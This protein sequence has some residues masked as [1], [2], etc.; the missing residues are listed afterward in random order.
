MSDVGESDQLVLRYLTL[1]WVVGVLSV[2]LPV[3]LVLGDLTIGS[4]GRLQDSISAYYDTVM[5][6]VFVGVLFA[7]GFFLFAYVGYP[8]EKEGRRWFQQLS[9]DSPWYERLSDNAAGNLAWVFALGVALFPVSG[10][11]LVKTVHFVSATALFLTLSYFSIVLFTKTS[12]TKSPSQ[13]KLARNRIYRWMGG[14]MLSCIGLMLVYNLWL[15]ETVVADWKP[16]LVL[17]TLALWAFGVSWFIKGETLLKD[18]E[19]SR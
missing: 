14:V 7:V 10:N 5:V 11:T 19:D 16:V 4:S 1:R 18:P 12:K 6:G 15:T 2:A 8:A 9:P 13:R 3:V 17:E